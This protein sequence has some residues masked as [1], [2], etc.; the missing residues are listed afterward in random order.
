MKRRFHLT[1]EYGT[2]SIYYPNGTTTHVAK[3]AGSPAYKAFMQ[4]AYHAAHMPH[5]SPLYDHAST[6]IN[7]PSRLCALTQSLRP[8][9][10]LT[11][12]LCPLPSDQSPT[13]DTAALRPVLTGLKRATEHALGGQRVC[14]VRL[15]GPRNVHNATASEHYVRTMLDAL[16]ATGLRSARYWVWSC[17]GVEEVDV[18]RDVTSSAAA[19]AAGALRLDVEEEWPWVSYV[20]VVEVTR[21]GG[22][23]GGPGLVT[24]AVMGDMLSTYE[25]G[26]GEVGEGAEVGEV[27]ERVVR[28]VV[29]RVVAYEGAEGFYRNL[30][31]VLVHG[32]GMGVSG[33]REALDRVLG[34]AKVG[35]T[36]GAEWD[37][38]AIFWGAD[39]TARSAY[40]TLGS[41]Q[42][43]KA[44]LGCRFMSGFYKD[45]WR[46]LRKDAAQLGWRELWEDAGQLGWMALWKHAL[47]LGCRDMWEYTVQLRWKELWEYA[48][49]LR[50]RE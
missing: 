44:A 2:A 18:L 13:D 39:G 31:S 23:N 43:Q 16:S 36:F 15:G 4:R 50:W 7:Q 5:S 3:I 1:A 27:V 19:A 28:D 33:V 35:E 29:E 47:Q 14:H 24:A 10:L 25:V 49:Q 46:E 45:G 22:E 11:P 40:E 41:M 37:D 21:R 9:R 20:V 6:N 30:V 48:V 17:G 38:D 32:D 34:E 8:L 42:S 12:Y 26:M